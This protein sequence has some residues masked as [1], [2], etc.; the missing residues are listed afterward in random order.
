MINL[1]MPFLS[2]LIAVML[3]ITAGQD[4]HAQ[5][6]ESARITDQLASEISQLGEVDLFVFADRAA[7]LSRM[8]QTL[9]LENIQ[10]PEKTFAKLPRSPFTVTG[11]QNGAQIPTCQIFVPANIT[12]E[13]GQEIF[14]QLMHGWFG[15]KLRYQS[16]ADLTY[17]WLIYHEVRHCKPDHYGGDDA[18]NHRDEIEADLFA[19]NELATPENKSQLASD[20]IAFRMITATL[21]ADRSH[22]TGLSIKYALETPQSRPTLSA[23]QEVAAF[24]GARQ[25]VTKQA[26]AIAVGVNPTNL[27]LIRAITEL[28]EAAENGKLGSNAPLIIEIMMSLDNAVAQFAPKL[29]GAVTTRQGN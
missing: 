8:D 11:R 7:F 25:L 20:I 4:L 9:G 16:T 10:S 15:P 12:P 29:H 19:F 1:R 22:M 17:R 28:R 13:R 21:F 14:A 27:E 18:Q 2:V 6:S 24:L 5:Q 23:K 26:K 3:C